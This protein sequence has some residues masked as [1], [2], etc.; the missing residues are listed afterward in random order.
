M[1]DITLIEVITAIDD[2]IAKLLAH[3]I[4]TRMKAVL[5]TELQKVGAWA[6]E[7]LRQ[8][9]DTVSPGEEE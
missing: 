7:T 8:E 5:V 9:G 4:K 2:L 6:R 1:R 3:S